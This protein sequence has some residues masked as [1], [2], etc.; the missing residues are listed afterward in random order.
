LETATRNSAIAMGELDE[1]G[2]IEVGKRADLVL[3]YA[4]PLDDIANTEQIAGVMARGQWLTASDLQ[5]MLDDIVASY[6]VIELVPFA[7]DELGVSGL[8]PTGWN[9]LEPGV[10][11]RGN[12]EV[13]P[14][15][16]LQLAAPGKSAEDFAL[17]VLADFGV[18][19]LPGSMDSYG[20]AALTW[21]L[22][23][24]ESQ[25]APL[26]LALGETDDAAYLVLLAAPGE[27]LDALVETV[28]FPA[29]HALTPIE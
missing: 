22:Y 21:E 7:D 23:Q 5:H 8:A 17:T 25:M 20:S 18:T 1:W 29:V 11:A 28:F 3:L 19:E 27:E 6:E 14:T 2:T 9:E 13:D 26:A 24:L 16:L 10:Y 15:L 4:D 12:P